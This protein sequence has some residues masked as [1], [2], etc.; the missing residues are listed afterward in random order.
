MA[1]RIRRKD[2][3]AQTSLRRI[4]REQVRAAIRGIDTTAGDT[5]DAIHDVRKRIKK[6]RGLLRLVRPSF[7]G[8]RDENAAFRQIAALLG[9]QRDA[10][11][12]IDTFDRL[13][14]GASPTGSGTF[15]SVRR[16]LL[17]H[18]R[19]IAEAHDPGALLRATRAALQD[20]LPRIE[21]WRLADDG[22]DAF[23]TGLESSY[24]RAR[25]AMR[26]AS[27][28]AEDEAFHDW[29]KRSKDHAFHLRLLQPVWPGPM[30]AI[31]A[32]AAELGDALGLHH[33]LAVLAA[34]VHAISDVDTGAVAALE[35]RIRLQQREPATRAGAL[36]ARL[37]ATPPHALAKSWRRRHAAWQ[38]ER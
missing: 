31:H 11:V 36:G 9:P 4:A 3:K 32:C 35:T 8:Y 13:V 30:R 19:A 27:A 12:L 7:D 33:D 20:A 6:I 38:R 1:Y 10:A 28:H 24:R 29:R 18:A 17:Q 15:A 5:A 16:Q 34:Y 21:R 25:K 14:E 2:S 26:A 22:F 23:E 37:Y